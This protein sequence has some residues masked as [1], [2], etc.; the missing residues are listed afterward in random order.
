[1]T[2]LNSCLL[3]VGL[4]VVLSVGSYCMGT[5][6]RSSSASVVNGA[7]CEC[8]DCPACFKLDINSPCN[9]IINQ[10]DCGCNK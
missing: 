3:L 9:C 7:V 10:C 5:S 4:F 2:N 8:V 6:E 1:M